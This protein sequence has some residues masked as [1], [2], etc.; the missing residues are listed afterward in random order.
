MTVARALIVSLVIACIEISAAVPVA[1]QD[2]NEKGIDFPTPVC[3]VFSNDDTMAMRMYA[4]TDHTDEAQATCDNLAGNGDW[5]ANG[6]PAG[7]IPAMTTGR[8]VRAC[9]VQLDPAGNPKRGEVVTAFIDV[10]YQVGIAGT[11]S[12]NPGLQ[13]WWNQQTASAVCNNAFPGYPTLLDD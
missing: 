13:S 1:A 4:S 12:A 11:A 8:F 7:M 9:H 2:T 10:Y 6:Y 5:V 3:G